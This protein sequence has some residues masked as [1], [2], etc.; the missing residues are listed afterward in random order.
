MIL[1]PPKTKHLIN[2]A[3]DKSSLVRM[4]KAVSSK[5]ELAKTIVNT[6]ICF[7]GIKLS[8]TEVTVLAYFMVYGINQ[9]TKNLLIKAEVCKNINNI[10]TIMVKLKKQEFIFKDDFDG[11]VKITK[12]LAFEL[13]P[14]VGFYLKLEHK[15]N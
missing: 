6:I 12:N 4:V 7:N 14:I 13:T 10:K 8:D 1:Q 15:A 11:K 3:Q 2:M 9:Q 5:V